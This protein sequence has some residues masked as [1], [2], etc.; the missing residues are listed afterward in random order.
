[1]TDDHREDIDALEVLMRS[2][3]WEL[4]A[5]RLREQVAN[6]EKAILSGSM[7]HD[8]YIQATTERAQALGIIEAPGRI[9]SALTN[10][11]EETA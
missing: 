10:A 7:E 6:L 5:A 8:R 2:A 9:H 1:M 4:V 3:G 11:S